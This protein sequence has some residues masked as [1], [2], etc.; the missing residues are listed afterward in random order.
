MPQTSISPGVVNLTW[1]ASTDNVGVTA[2]RIYRDGNRIATVGAETSYADQ[3]VSPETSYSY[4]VQ[5]V[6]A[7]TNASSLSTALSVTTP[8]SAPVF[9]DTFESGNLS[10]WTTVSGL[11]AE[12][13]D[14][15]GGSWAAEGVGAGTGVAN[16]WKTLPAAQTSLYYQLHFK[17][18]SM[19]A[20][21]VYLERFRTAYGAPSGSAASI[22]GIYVSTTGKLGFRNDVAGTSLTSS[23]PVTLGTWHTLE[24]HV[25]VA[26]S[27]G[28]VE[29]WLDGTSVPALSV[30]QSL[31]TD[32]TGVIQLGE[33]ASGKTYDV[34]F[35][36]VKV[37]T[38]PLP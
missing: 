2:Y 32:P 23:T 18:V 27:S 33:N 24:V 10:N 28:Q 36:D 31:G 19:G 9:G 3:S 37:D 12:Q 6:D 17:I 5:A 38:V 4:Q 14:V 25:A 29:T 34:R 7:S 21:T 26:G 8:S 16:A 35:D 1:S 20:N 13:A 30:T 11:A 22:L 15:A